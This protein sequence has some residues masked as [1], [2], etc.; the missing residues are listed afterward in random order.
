[1]DDIL[2]GWEDGLRLKARVDAGNLTCSHAEAG[3]IDE[4]SIL[5]SKLAKKGLC[6]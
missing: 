1:M 5:L 2:V 6:R 3:G 4:Q